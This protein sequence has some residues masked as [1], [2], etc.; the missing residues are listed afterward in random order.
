MGQAL[1]ELVRPRRP[2]GLLHLGIRSILPAHSDVVRYRPIEEERVLGNVRD[3]LHKLTER[4][5]ANVVPA[6]TN[7]AAARIPKP[8]HE[9]RDG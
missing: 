1:D 2:G 7:R 9:L 4:N 8:C 5:V 6:V 3:M